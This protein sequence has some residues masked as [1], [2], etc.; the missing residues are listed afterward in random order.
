[1]SAMLLGREVELLDL[2]TFSRGTE[3]WDWGESGMFELTPAGLPSY[4]HEPISGKLLGIGIN[5]SATNRLPWSGIPEFTGNLGEEPALSIFQGKVAKK[6]I[7]LH[8]TT[9]SVGFYQGAWIV[10]ESGFS[11]RV[12]A[13]SIDDNSRIMMGFRN[14]DV[15]TWERSF[16]LDLNDP[17]AVP[18]GFSGG[19]P[20][21]RLSTRV[22]TESGPN[23]GVLWELFMFIGAARNPGDSIA[24]YFYPGFVGGGVQSASI[25]HHRQLE[26]GPA[27][28]PP[29]WTEDVALRRES[30]LCWIKD[31]GYPHEFPRT[32]YVEMA[33]DLSDGV[34]ALI[35]GAGFIQKDGGYRDRV[36]LALHSSDGLGPDVIRGYCQIV[37]GVDGTASFSAVRNEKPPMT[38]MKLALSYSD[39]G[40]V[41]AVN[42][43]ATSGVGGAEAAAP[44]SDRQRLTIGHVITAGRILNGYIKEVRVEPEA[45][46]QEELAE[47]TAL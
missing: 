13:E 33:G 6:V 26:N 10:P 46:S 32:L 18:R 9:S 41:W 24:P 22:L 4:K 29:I 35:G 42:G 47:M 23:G 20:T 11:Y 12:Y 28:T 3:K 8:P 36:S 16:I 39:A 30:D 1:M 14:Q 44:E 38:L 19:N 15:P 2:V 31:I 25:V 43:Q 21:A 17:N 40:H 5:K 7:N 45:K 34:D 37:S 27:P